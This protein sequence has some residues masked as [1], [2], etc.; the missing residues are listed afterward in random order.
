MSKTT[1]QTLTKFQVKDDKGQTVTL[2]HLKA[3]KACRTLGIRLAPDRNNKD[4]Y[5]HLKEVALE[6]C[7]K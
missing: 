3:S 2:P 7:Q 1:E 5:Q 6:W 4:E